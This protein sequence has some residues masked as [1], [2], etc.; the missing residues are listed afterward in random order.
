MSK[1]CPKCGNELSDEAKFCNECGYSVLVEDKKEEISKTEETNKSEVEVSET[2]K[3]KNAES[4]KEEQVEVSKTNTDEFLFN[5]V[6]SKSKSNDKIFSNKSS[7]NLSKNK[8]LI[9]VAFVIILIICV[10]MFSSNLFY[11]PENMSITII[12]ISGSSDDDGTCY[13][14][15][16]AIFSNLP[17]NTEGYLIKTNYCDSNGKTL[18]TTTEGLNS[19]DANE[20]G[21]YFGFYSSPKYLA[22]DHVN[23]EIIHEGKVIKEA[24]GDFDSNKADFYKDTNTTES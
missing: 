8:L 10:F 7:L 5:E 19:V 22:V 11:N 9:P 20:Y 2:K 14:N 13:Y 24:K 21:S 18:A 3:E 17:P 12:D 4:L 15:V 1:Y 6:P 16:N 23:V